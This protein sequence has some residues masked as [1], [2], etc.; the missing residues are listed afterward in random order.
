MTS[1]LGAHDGSS[2]AGVNGFAF[3]MSPRFTT[4]P[5]VFWEGGVYGVDRD[6]ECGKPVYTR[7]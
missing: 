7:W 4:G 3:W 6:V 5:L 1:N 2:V